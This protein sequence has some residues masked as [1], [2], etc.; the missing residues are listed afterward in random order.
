MPITISAS[1]VLYQSK[2]EHVEKVIKD[3]LASPLAGALFL[4]DNSP[5]DILK[6]LA[7][8]DPR[9]AYQW[10]P[11]NIGFGRGHNIA[12]NKML[13]KSKYHLVLNPDI[14]FDNRVIPTLF[15]FME[16]HTDVGNV[17]PKVHYK[18]GEVQPL[19][20]LLPTPLT[21]F[22][23]RFAR[24]SF[25][26][27]KLN[28]RYELQHFR[29]NHILEVP[30]MSGCFMFLRNTVLQQTGG[31]D[32]HFF[33]YL[34]DVD[35]NRRIGSISKTVVYPYVSIMH[36]FRKGS[37]QEFALLKHHIRSAIYYFNK[38][39][40]FFDKERVERNN[41]TVRSIK[42]LNKAALM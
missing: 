29:Y 10:L 33:M 26:T 32:E 1:I 39:G 5:A 27:R 14:E 25:F 22:S 38:W 6:D 20:K 7:S 24:Y 13:G 21:L 30:N 9:I 18:T 23:R 3:F 41:A 40:W 8:I 17:I 19:C 11:Q 37:Y 28:R 15:A 31:F 35:L 34:E 36:H 4:I 16:A 2:R 12:I 42:A